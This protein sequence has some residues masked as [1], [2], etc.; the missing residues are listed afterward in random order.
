MHEVAIINL[1]NTNT[2]KSHLKTYTIKTM[3]TNIF[4]YVKKKIDKRICLMQVRR[5][6]YAFALTVENQFDVI[7]HVK[8]KLFSSSLR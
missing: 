6:R 2:S 1:I 7:S 4:K 8:I 3:S 5:A